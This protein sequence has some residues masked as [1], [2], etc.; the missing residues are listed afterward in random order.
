VTPSFLILR[1]N[2]PTGGARARDLTAKWSMQLH[3]VV[4]DD[5]LIVLASHGI[6]RS[7]PTPGL[8]I[9]GHIHGGMAEQSLS[10]AGDM[11]RALT[12]QTWGNYLAIG[13]DPD[14]CLAMVDPSGAGRAHLASDGDLNL[15]TDALTPQLMRDAGLEVEV[16]MAALAGCLTDPG[17]I[18][19]APLLKGVVPMVAGVAYDL[20]GRRGPERIWAPSDIGAGGG[21]G[22]TL[23]RAVDRTI[24]GMLKG[25][26][27]LIELSGGLDSSIIAGSM[28][29]LGIRPRAVNVELIGGDVDEVRYARATAERCGIDLRTVKVTGYPDLSAIMAVE[30]VAHPYIWGL[31]RAFSDAV[32]AGIDG[33]VDCVVTGQGGDAVFYQPATPYTTIDHVRARGWRSGR[34]ALLDDARRSS[35][36]VWALLEAVVA[37]RLRG[38]RLPQ[39]ELG[40]GLM[41]R[42]AREG[43]RRFRHAWLADADDQSPGRRLHLAMI[44]N[45][46]MFHSARPLDPGR[47]V[48]HPLL[49]QPVLEAALA[50]PTWELACGSLDRDLAR[51]TFADRLAPAVAGRRSKGAASAFYSRTALANLPYLRERLLDGALVAAGIIDGAALETMLTPEALFY[52][53]D[54]PALIVQASGEA[55]LSAWTG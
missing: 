48:L 13:S 22:H 27:P 34:A 19:S 35:T 20:G 38:T 5:R 15:V 55:W 11:L 9:F 33:D 52:S 54:Y 8:L 30:Q 49:S 31:D 44:A 17:T 1:W 7:A 37:D 39:D 51:R 3:Q 4:S 24:A 10:S 2:T 26:T 50:L 18:V 46:Q 47:H 42:E 23:R 45:S 16:D 21:D 53:L 36:S 29:D 25:R 14:H 32:G 12:R 40:A 28:V 6:P 43:R 41:T